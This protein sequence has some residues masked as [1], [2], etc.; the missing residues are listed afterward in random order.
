MAWREGKSME[1]EKESSMERNRAS[2]REH[3]AAGQPKDTAAGKTVSVIVPV[4]NAQDY[5]ERCVDSIMG[6]T[7]PNL[8]IL[9][10]DDGARDESPAMCDR[11]AAQDGRIRVLHKENGGMISAWMAGV[12]MAT[13][14]YLT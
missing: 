4:Y 13:G 8:E 14:D 5:L 1:A 7:Y 6:Q 2:E 11:F 10:V 9:L 3:A 12:Q